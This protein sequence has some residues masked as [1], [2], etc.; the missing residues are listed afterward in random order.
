MLCGIANPRSVTWSLN[1]SF[2]VN[3][4]CANVA[5]SPTASNAGNP[6][7][8]TAICAR[9]SRCLNSFSTWQPIDDINF[10]VS[11]AQLSDKIKIIQVTATTKNFH[12]CINWTKNF[13]FSHDLLADLQDS[14][15]FGLV[16]S[17]IGVERML[18]FET[19]SP[20]CPHSAVQ[21]YFGQLWPCP[22]HRDQTTQHELK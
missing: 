8:Y 6:L 18:A 20:P 5:G 21:L 7:R 19:C 1:S 4:R 12:T 10:C 9:F 13:P 15:S 2:Q 22:G 14:S 17:C 3:H 11:S 16:S